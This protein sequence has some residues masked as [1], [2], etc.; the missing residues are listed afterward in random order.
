MLWDC[1]LSTRF[2]DSRPNKTRMQQKNVRA[3]LQYQLYLKC[4]HLQ[5][6]SGD[7]NE[8]WTIVIYAL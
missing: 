7:Q 3:D 5:E 1:L 2:R 4:T 8:E 6:Q